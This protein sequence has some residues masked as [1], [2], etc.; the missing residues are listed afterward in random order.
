MNL[1]HLHIHSLTC[2]EYCN[3][4]T[5]SS[6]KMAYICTYVSD[7]MWRAYFIRLG[8]TDTVC[9]RFIEIFIRKN[10]RKTYKMDYMYFASII[11]S[12]FDKKATIS[13]LNSENQI[14]ILRDSKCIVTAIP[15]Y[16]SE[17][18]QKFPKGK[19]IIT[20]DQMC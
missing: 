11:S 6:K 4:N 13:S 17:L 7:Y 15:L 1:V 5:K 3:N 9:F 10:Y 16:E 2:R 18:Q 8:H 12:I 19:L 20:I 14:T